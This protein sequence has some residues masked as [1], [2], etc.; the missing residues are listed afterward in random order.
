MSGHSSYEWLEVEYLITC[1][2]EAANVGLMLL[3]TALLLLRLPL[4]E[5]KGN[6][7]QG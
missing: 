6:A 7:A 5:G 4:A 3:S 2:V 1:A